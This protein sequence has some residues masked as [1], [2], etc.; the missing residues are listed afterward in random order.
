MAIS[1]IQNASLA[2][3]VPGSTNL[4][5]GTVLQVIQGTYATQ[6]S[7]TSTSYVS[8]GL[9]ATITPK[10]AT[11]K[12]LVMVSV[13]CGNDRYAW[14]WLTVYRNSSTN[15]AGGSGNPGGYV[16]NGSSVTDYLETISFQILDAPATTSAT[17]YTLY[18]K[19]Q[20][21]NTV[22]T[23]PDNMPSYITLIEVAV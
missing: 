7:T 20:N 9:T 2:S 3:G 15:I 21:G 12:V 23:C 14:Q 5:A 18:T 10:S 19:G 13:V 1:T 6:E 11:S 17:T 22:R 16:S 4:P 8:R